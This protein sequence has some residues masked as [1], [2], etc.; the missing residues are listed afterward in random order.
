M[1]VGSTGS[2]EY[3]FAERVVA[4]F[5]GGSQVEGECIAEG[6]DFVLSLGKL[7]LWLCLKLMLR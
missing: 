1:R 3:R 4:A 2:D 5:G 7:C 6:D